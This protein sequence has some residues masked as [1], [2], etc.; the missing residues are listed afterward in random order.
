LAEQPRET[1]KEVLRS[2]DWKKAKMES[3]KKTVRWIFDYDEEEEDEN[4]SVVDSSDDEEDTREKEKPKSLLKENP[5]H[6][7]KEKRRS[8]MRNSLRDSMSKLKGAAKSVTMAKEPVKKESKRTSWR[9]S[10]GRGKKSTAEKIRDKNLSNLGAI[11]EDGEYKQAALEDSNVA[12]IG[13]EDDV[14]QRKKAAKAE[15]HFNK[16]GKKAGLLIWRVENKRTKSGA[17]D[18]GINKWPKAEYG[19]FFSGDSYIVLNSYH[20]DKKKKNGRFLHDVHFWLGKD[21]T[22]DEI[23]VAAYKTVE[24]SAL[25]DAVHHREI[26]H[27]ESRL[28]QSYFKELIY[29]DG[30]IDSGFRH[31]KPIEYKPRLLMVRHTKQSRVTKAYTIPCKASCMNRGDCFVLDAGEVVYRYVGE[32]SNFFEKNRSGLLQHNIVASRNGKAIK[33]DSDDP[34][35]WKILGGS[36][37]DVKNSEHPYEVETDTTGSLNASEIRLFR[38]SDSSGK[39][40]FT[41]EAEGKI[42]YRALDSNDVFLVHANIGIWIWIGS[43]A[44]KQEAASGMAYAD[45]YIRKEGLPNT[46]AVS[47]ITEDQ[48]RVH[49]LFNSLFRGK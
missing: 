8:S 3:I 34:E 35:F 7:P 12:G 22:Q 23:G 44:T 48:A 32:E 45:E 37:A 21:S 43:R 28:F 30:G 16:V 25:V 47:S 20:E 9:N 26:Q 13:S 33:A 2:T 29:M 10:F 36:E 24:L 11:S 46:L 5:K 27:H 39:L 6:D 14:E 1:Y 42:P 49:Q 4:N 38:I 40:E 19:N 15:K 17:P 18:F 41:T 31:V